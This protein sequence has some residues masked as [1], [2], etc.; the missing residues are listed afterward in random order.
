M[1]ESIFNIITA[2]GVI[3]TLLFTFLSYL[4]TR[5]FN[6]KHIDLADVQKKL[7]LLLLQRENRD[8]TDSTKADIGAR[9]YSL[10]NRSHKIRIY[11]QGKAT[12][13]NVNLEIL[14]GEENVMLQQITSNFPKDFKTHESVDIAVAFSIGREPKIILKA[15]WSDDSA[16]RR[17]E[18]ISLSL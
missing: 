16:E 8:L 2:I 10:N 1:D 18:I 12:A 14:E 11:N 5:E 4:N 3:F 13:R 15:I 6:R 7:N 9:L 17:E